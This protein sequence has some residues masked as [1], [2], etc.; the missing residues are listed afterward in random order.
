M[1]IVLLSLGRSFSHVRQCSSVSNSGHP[2]GQCCS[3]LYGKF[4]LNEGAVLDLNEK[5]SETL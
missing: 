1:S 3:L 5:C 2:K 4:A